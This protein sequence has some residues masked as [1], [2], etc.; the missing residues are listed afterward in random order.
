[1]AQSRRNVQQSS[2][3]SEKEKGEGAVA[4]VDPENGGSPI[5]APTREPDASAELA[6]SICLFWSGILSRNEQTLR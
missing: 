1:M 6:E 2:R 3:A 4:E 5:A